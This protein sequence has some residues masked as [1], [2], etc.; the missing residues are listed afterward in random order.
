MPRSWHTTDTSQ[1]QPSGGPGQH[2]TTP[3]RYLGASCPDSHGVDW[4]VRGAWRGRP[5]PV[6]RHLHLT[7]GVRS[8][9]H[10]PSVTS[11]IQLLVAE[12]THIIV[13]LC[14]GAL[15][16][17]CLLPA[18]HPRGPLRGPTGGPRR[19][20]TGATSGGGAF[21][22]ISVGSVQCSASPR[23]YSSIESWPSTPSPRQLAAADRTHPIHP[24]RLDPA[25]FLGRNGVARRCHHSHCVP[26][27]GPHRRH[28]GHNGTA[29]DLRHLCRLRHHSGERLTAHPHSAEF[30]CWT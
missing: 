16:T 11:L 5:H 19:L 27:R 8:C 1:V 29:R 15:C 9:V 4:P 3:N 22:A 28:R 6:T 20:G 12:H 17:V 23:N 2:H 21:S 18:L 24:T 7:S 13:P 14:Q 10:R 25:A 30:P 26:L